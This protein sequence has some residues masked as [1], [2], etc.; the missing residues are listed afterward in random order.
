MTRTTRRTLIRATAWLAGGVALAPLA[1]RAERGELRMAQG[2]GV[3]FLPLLVMKDFKLVE[4]LAKLKGVLLE[5]VTWAQFSGGAVMTD[6]LISG[7][8]DIAAGGV[9]P[10]IK[11]WA[12]TTSNLKI[13]GIAS[14]G[15]SPMLLN[16]TNPAVRTLADFTA[17]DKIA[18][19]AVRGSLQAE[20]LQ[21]ACAK[22]WGIDSYAKLDPLTVSM[23]HPDAMAALLSGNVTTHFANSPYQEQELQNAKVRTV[24]SSTDVLGEPCSVNTL[25]C[26]E[27]FRT[28]NP[29]LYGAAWSAY[30]EAIDWI[31]QDKKRASEFY[32]KAESSPLSADLVRK[33][34]SAEDYQ[35]S[36][37]P[38]GTMKYAK[39][40]GDV[41]TISQQP[42]TWK[43]L[44]FPEVHALQG[45]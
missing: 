34:I 33:I 35:Y 27:K 4:K 39:F 1:V 7:N 22:Q 20:V 30:R 41:K 29:G 2:F 28:E 43:D 16:T 21:M 18:L 25:F 13:K 44:F 38:R 14:L 3:S 9:T 5:K 36:P 10:L 19:P 42:A 12:K 23:R 24:L 15:T 11:L 8:L 40:L 45:S 31:N 26:S 6:A 37:V 17:S 32:V